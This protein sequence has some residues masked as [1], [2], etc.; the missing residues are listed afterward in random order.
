MK[1]LCTVLVIV[2]FIAGVVVSSFAG[3]YIS[4]KENMEERTQI[5]V[6]LSAAGLGFTLAYLTEE[7]T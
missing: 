7:L 4:N 1:K 3:N 2:F 6:L 5:T